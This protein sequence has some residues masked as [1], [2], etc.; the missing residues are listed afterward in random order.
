MGR[1]GRLFPRTDVLQAPS[2]PNGGRKRAV[3]PSQ[4]RTSYRP[5]EPTRSTPA[6]PPVW[7]SCEVLV[8]SA[9]VLCACN[10]G[11][12]ACPHTTRDASTFLLPPQHVRVFLWRVANKPL[13]FYIAGLVSFFG[14]LLG[15]PASVLH[16]CGGAS[17]SGGVRPCRAGATDGSGTSRTV[18]GGIAVGTLPAGIVT[19]RAGS[20]RT[21]EGLQVRRSRRILTRTL[22]HSITR[23]ISQH[24]HPRRPKPSGIAPHRILTV[25]AEDSSRFSGRRSFISCCRGCT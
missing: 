10:P 3:L 20:G 15:P 13:L 19:T 2:H 12:F 8:E 7:K 4:D 24:Q 18:A 16:P 22:H 14:R 1:G 11:T 9:A 5:V 21:R 6:R 23:T 25:T 17:S